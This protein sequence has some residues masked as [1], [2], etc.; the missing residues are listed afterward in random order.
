MVVLQA[1]GAVVA[2]KT[3][4][5]GYRTSKKGSWSA[6]EMERSRKLMNLV[7]KNNTFLNSF[8]RERS[9]WKVVKGKTIIG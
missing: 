7:V 8:F 5:V 6:S 3:W 2:L 4:W 9:G 1:Q